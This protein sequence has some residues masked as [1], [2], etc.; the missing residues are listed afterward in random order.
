MY[1]NNYKKLIAS[2]SPSKQKFFSKAFIREG[3]LYM[4][5]RGAPL[6]NCEHSMATRNFACAAMA[7]FWQDGQMAQN[8]N[9]GRG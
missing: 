7:Q 1:N 4:T 8:T 9:H 2:F 3:G 6:T 5:V